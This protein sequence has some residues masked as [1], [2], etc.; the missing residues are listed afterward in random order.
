MAQLA[1]L[2]EHM[3]DLLSEIRDTSS[4]KN[5]DYQ[6][7]ADVQ[8]ERLLSKKYYNPYDVLLLK[9]EA[10]DEEIKKAHKTVKIFPAKIPE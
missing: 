10:A 9:S 7:T 4:T 8:L 1:S 6:M 3:K 5:K 2:D